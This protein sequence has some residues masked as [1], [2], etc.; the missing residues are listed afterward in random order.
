MYLGMFAAAC[1]QSEKIVG[2]LDHV[3]EA[4]EIVETTQERWWEPELYRQRGVLLLELS[5]GN[6]T[7]AE[8]C[9]HQALEVARAQQ[10]KS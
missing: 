10:A 3:T 6:H 2:G 1:E 4:L 8:S 7:E 9:F 5:S